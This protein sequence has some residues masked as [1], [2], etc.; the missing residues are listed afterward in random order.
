MAA[1]RLL[2][3]EDSS[4][5]RRMIS[6]LLGDEG[7]E[8]TTAVDGADGLVKA[9]EEPR[10]DLILTDFEMPEMDGAA[11]CREVKADKELRSTPVLLLTTLGETRNKVV[12]L[13]SGADDYIQKPKNPDEI[14]ELFA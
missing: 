14:Q 2:L 9:R 8:V 11:L 4:T 6:T 7:Y 3:V 13:D 10:P 1:R 5:M 12:G